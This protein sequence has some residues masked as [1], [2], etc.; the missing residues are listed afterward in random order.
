MLLPPTAKVPER[1]PPSAY[2]SLS[3]R[4]GAAFRAPVKVAKMLATF[5][6]FGPDLVAHC[7]K[8][9]GGRCAAAAAGREVP[10]SRTETGLFQLHSVPVLKPEDIRYAWPSQEH[11]AFVIL[12]KQGFVRKIPDP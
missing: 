2:S 1:G 6:R 10:R 8:Q 11:G 12:P 7:H 3:W 5:T 9:R 4:S